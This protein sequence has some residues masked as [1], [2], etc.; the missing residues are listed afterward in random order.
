MELSNRVSNTPA[1]NHEPPAP[2]TFGADSS[3]EFPHHYYY[4]SPTQD[5]VP[6]G[7]ANHNTTTMTARSPENGPAAVAAGLN[8]GSVSPRTTTTTVSPAKT[9]TFEL[10]FPDSPAHRARLP[11]RVSI[12]THDT[13]ESIVTTVKNFYGLYS[14]GTCGMGISFEDDDGNTLIARYENFRHNM[15]VFVR[16]F[17]E[18]S[19]VPPA[20]SPRS[21][22]SPRVGMAGDD[23]DSYTM[24]GQHQY[25]HHTSRP[26]S[27]TSRLRSP[28][29]HSARGRRSDSAGANSKK[30]R[31]RS[32]KNRTMNGDAHSDSMSGYGSGDGGP[33]SVSGRAKEQLGN[34]EI[35]VENI[36]EGGRR[37][38]PKFDSSVRSRPA[39]V[40]VA[41]VVC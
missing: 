30:G 35:S 17:G 41:G 27:R 22:Q 32:S 23:G 6:N 24:H 40:A 13:T 19:P 10:M 29:P 16:V 5:R 11:L 12:F 18:P 7:I 3:P 20:F 26:A 1:Q 14:S 28:S 2:P 9:V 38:R 34:T 36:V 31:S 21:F 39:T 25:G 33:S 8:S 37:K 4:P 15:T